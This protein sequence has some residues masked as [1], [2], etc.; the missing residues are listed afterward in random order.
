L[1]FGIAPTDP[2]GKSYVPFLSTLEEGYADRTGTSTLVGNGAGISTG[3]H[4]DELALRKLMAV[5]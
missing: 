3:R 1:N 2:R 4:G 5:E